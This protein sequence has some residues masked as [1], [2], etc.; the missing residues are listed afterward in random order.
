MR[1]L[2]CHQRKTLQLDSLHIVAM[3]ILETDG[4]GGQYHLVCCVIDPLFSGLV[5]FQ[6]GQKEK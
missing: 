1:S 3:M 2:K 4:G 6:K 5:E